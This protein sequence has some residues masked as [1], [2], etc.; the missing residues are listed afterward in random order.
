MTITV[1]IKTGNEAMRTASDVAE[2]LRETANIVAS[3]GLHRSAKHVIRDVNG[4]AIG[5]WK[6]G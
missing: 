6:V 3:R 2:A 5:E 1:K 4:N